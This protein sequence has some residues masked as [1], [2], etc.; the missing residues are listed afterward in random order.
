MKG[1]KKNGREKERRDCIP[2]YETQSPKKRFFQ[3]HCQCNKKYW[4]YNERAGNER[5]L[6]R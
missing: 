3:R 4:Q 6:E 1:G 5:F 2:G